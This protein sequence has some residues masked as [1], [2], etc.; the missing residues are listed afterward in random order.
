MYCSIAL[1]GVLGV[2]RADKEFVLRVCCI[3]G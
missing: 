3:V 2:Y 1:G